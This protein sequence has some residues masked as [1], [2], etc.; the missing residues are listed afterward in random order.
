MRAL[1]I[2]LFFI[3]IFPAA[4]G[5][6]EF[7]IFY[8]DSVCTKALRV[9]KA[10]N[11]IKFQVSTPQYKEAYYELFPGNFK[12]LY[13]LFGYQENPDK[14]GILYYDY[15]NLVPEFFNDFFYHNDTDFYE[16]M[17]VIS[18]GGKWYSEGIDLYQQQMRKEVQNNVELSS[19]ILNKM[20]D[21]DV[22]D[23]W[24]FYFDGPPQPITNYDVLKNLKQLN[25]RVF[26]LMV[27]VK[28]EM[29]LTDTMRH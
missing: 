20:A 7:R 28:P 25:E 19:Y 26:N 24:K 3:L 9:K 15:L 23:F 22:R 1:Y 17:M 16:K 6:Q 2:V 13:Q 27:K 8:N 21:D 12:D 10:Y 18:M 4:Y 11:D 5:Q 14:F 29:A